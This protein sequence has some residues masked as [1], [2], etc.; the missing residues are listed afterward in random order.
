VFNAPVGFDV[1]GD[2]YDRFMGRY[3]RQLAP[4]FADFAGVDRGTRVLDV[5][6]GPGVLSRELVARVGSE[7]VAAID[8][9]QSF[10]AAARERLPGADVREATAEELPFPDGEFDAALSQLVVA[11]MQDAV[12]GV[13]EMRRVTR[14]GGVVAAAM[15]DFSGGMEMLRTLHTAALA[16]APEHPAVQGPRRYGSEAELRELFERAGVR[17]V[18]AAP[19]DVESTYEDFDEL[20]SAV[21]ESA[22]PIGEI[23]RDLDE[24]GVGRYR[25]EIR[26]RLG[27]PAGPFTLRARAWAVRGRP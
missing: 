7:N 21:L 17:D 3:S 8:P 20:W 6:C 5:G 26:S 13:G 1:S 22:G 27:E 24:E 23:V 10:V 12:A 2:A 19:L 25:E 9:S 14:Q 18:E 4:L 11:F 16:V 15:W